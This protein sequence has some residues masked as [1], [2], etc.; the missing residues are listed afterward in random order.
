MVR[1]HVVIGVFLRKYFHS[2]CSRENPN[3]HNHFSNLSKIL[4]FES[5]KKLIVN[6]FP[7]EKFQIFESKQNKIFWK[8]SNVSKNSNFEY[9]Q[10]LLRTNFES[11]QKFKFWIWT[12]SYFDQ[13]SNLSKIWFWIKFESEQKDNFKQISNLSKICSNFKFSRICK[14]CSNLKL[15]NKPKK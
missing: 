5:E 4:N 3:M 7:W 12:K 6:K 2:C 9:E 13:I 1:G 14:I 8:F 10:K 11:E 15:K